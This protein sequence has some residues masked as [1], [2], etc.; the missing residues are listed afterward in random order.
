VQNFFTAFHSS[1]TSPAGS[2]GNTEGLEL[3]YGV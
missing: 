2:E 1:D 3:D